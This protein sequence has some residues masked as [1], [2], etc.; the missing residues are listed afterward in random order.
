MSVPVLEFSGSQAVLRLRRNMLKV[1][2]EARTAIRK[3]LREAGQQV[4]ADARGN[5]SW[6]SRIGG[7]MR[8]RTSFSSRRPGVFI[9]VDRNKAPHARPFEGI[10]QWS[11]RHPV[12]GNREVWVEQASR[13][14]LVPAL[15]ENEG[16]AVALIASTV[17]DVLAK[18]GITA[19]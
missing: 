18:L 4:L 2:Q 13:P 10:V 8:I 9:Q 5:A 15:D 3:P 6:S 16:E 1:P 11:F 19:S 7:A 12:F 17:E 14:Y